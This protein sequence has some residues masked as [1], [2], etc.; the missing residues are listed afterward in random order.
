MAQGRYEVHFADLHTL[1]GQ[2]VLKPDNKIINLKVYYDIKYAAARNQ[3][4]KEARRPTFTLLPCRPTS[5]PGK[6]LTP[7]LPQISIVSV[8][9]GAL[10][11][12]TAGDS[13]M[14]AAYAPTHF[15][16]PATVTLHSFLT[17]VLWRAA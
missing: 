9:T 12:E 4:R 17:L 6:W 16:L 5:R 13:V 8:A 14:H 1:F 2:N 10:A 3:V 11:V 15:T 7:R